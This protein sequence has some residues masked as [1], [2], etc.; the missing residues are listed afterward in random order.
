MVRNHTSRAE[1]NVLRAA[2]VHR[3]EPPGPNPTIVMPGGIV[4]SPADY[5]LAWIILPQAGM[6]KFGK[7]TNASLQRAQVAAIMTEVSKESAPGLA[8][9]FCRTRRRAEGLWLVSS[10]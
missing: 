7:G 5:P 2:S 3:S 1:V 8:L 9:C 6:L 10:Q 4:S